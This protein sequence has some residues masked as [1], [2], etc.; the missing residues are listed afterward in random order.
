[1]MFFVGE[2]L[3]QIKL[4][5]SVDWAIYFYKKKEFQKAIGC[6]QKA[7]LLDP[8][9]Y[10]ANV[11]LAATLVANKS[12]RESLVS[13]DKAIS[14]RKPDAWTLFPLLVAYK[15]LGA[16]DLARKALEG[17]MEF[18]NNNEAATY[19]GLA[20]TY[21]TLDMFEEAEHYSKRALEISPNESGLHYNLGK[22][23]F[24]QQ[25]PKEAK[26][27]FQ[28]AVELADSKREKRLKRYAIHYLKDIDKKEMKKVV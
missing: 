19:D 8:N 14:I 4:A 21:F 28:R 11:G 6:Y 1:M 15:A 26:V 2:K 7:L 5:C 24:A 27:E 9:D 10:Y 16:D 22:I 12:F 17:I 23:Y 18:S 20:Y 13:F 25:K 3:K